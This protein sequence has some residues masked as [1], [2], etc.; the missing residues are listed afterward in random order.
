MKNTI[1]QRLYPA[2][3]AAAA[4]ALAGVVCRVEAADKNAF[5]D[6]RE[7][8]SYALGMNLAHGWNQQG[9]EV[10]PDMV[11]QGMKDL[12]G[13]GKTRLSEAEVQT[14]IQHIG[15]ELRELQEE[16]RKQLAQ[17]NDEE[18][19]AFLARNQTNQGVV[20]LPDGLQYK[21]LREGKGECPDP[22]NFV[23][24]RYHRLRLDGSKF[25]GQE[26]Q[27]QTRIY[28]MRGV[29]RG[30]ADALQ[31]MRPGARWLLYVPAE[32]AYGKDGSG[33]AGPNET[34]VFELDLI[35]VLPGPPPPT[36]KD[37]RSERAPDGD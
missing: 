12:L 2:L 11:A 33:E 32:L 9:L 14:T 29:L 24:V 35:K 22:T 8:N 4:L 36:A 28:S 21:I 7:K 23:S 16:R 25:A 15:Q 27:P 20:C 26:S 17:K 5:K 13:G 37:L 3:A 10:D 18:G 31:M 1:L 19:K 30:W 34:L 6:E